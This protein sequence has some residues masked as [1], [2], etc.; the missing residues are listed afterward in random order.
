MIITGSSKAV[1]PFGVSVRN[2]ALA[3]QRLMEA[4][5]RPH[6]Y[7][8]SSFPNNNNNIIISVFDARLKI[9]I[10]TVQRFTLDMEVHRLFQ[11]KVE[12]TNKRGGRPKF[13][14]DHTVPSQF[15]VKHA[16]FYGTGF[17]RGH[18]VPAADYVGDDDLYLSTFV[19]TNI[20]P[21]C[22]H[23]NRGVWCQAEIESRKLVLGHLYLYSNNGLDTGKTKPVAFVITV[24]LFLPKWFEENKR[25]FEFLALGN[26]LDFI[27]VPTHFCKVIVLARTE[28]SAL[29]AAS[30]S[31]LLQIKRIHSYMVPN[32]DLEETSRKS[33]W[34]YSVS[35]DFLKGLLGLENLA[36]KL[37]GLDSSWKALPDALTDKS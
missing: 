9:P 36:K 2:A 5:P 14:L 19:D 28:S 8:N 22:A 34:K 7:V 6:C 30:G 32:D 24:P 18:M 17:D 4:L 11:N 21:Q 3:R 31:S 29:S 33:L 13:V 1:L 16:H 23:V 20:S 27:A 26:L 35:W 10:C 15:Q 12:R 25:Q 37:P